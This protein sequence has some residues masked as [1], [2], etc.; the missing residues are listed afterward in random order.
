MTEQINLTAFFSRKSAS[1]PDNISSSRVAVSLSTND[2]SKMSDPTKSKMIHPI[3]MYLWS[4][5]E[6]HALPW[7]DQQGELSL[8]PKAWIGR[9]SKKER[10]VLSKVGLD[11]HLKMVLP[12]F[13]YHSLGPMQ[14]RAARHRI[15]QFWT[16]NTMQKVMQEFLIPDDLKVVFI[17][18]P[19]NFWRRLTG[20]RWKKPC[21][22]LW[23][24][25]RVPRMC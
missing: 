25:V 6:S 18:M 4:F 17:A 23:S 21:W 8:T 13:P 10:K 7:V 22:Q 15:G 1:T 16:S 20:T 11:S 19:W 14:E 2:A 12:T 3:Q 5:A 9:A 24:P